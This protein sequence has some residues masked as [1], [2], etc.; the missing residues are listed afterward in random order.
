MKIA[1]L[2][3]FSN[4]LDYF[5]SSYL[6]IY[7]NLAPGKNSFKKFLSQTKNASAISIMSHTTVHDAYL[8]LKRHRFI[9]MSQEVYISIAAGE[10]TL[11]AFVTSVD[12]D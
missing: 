6:N 9:Y 1:K 5:T 12:P 2:K 8:F 10:P 11:R 4:T 3:Q 7:M